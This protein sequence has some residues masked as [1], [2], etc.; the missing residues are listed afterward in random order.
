VV[1][2][3]IHRMNSAIKA[4]RKPDLVVDELLTDAAN[5]YSYDSRLVRYAI[6]WAFYGNDVYDNIHSWAKI[7]KSQ[8]ELYRHIRNIYNPTKRIIDFWRTHLWGDLKFNTNENDQLSDDITQILNW[9][10]WQSN[11]VIAAYQ[12]SLFGDTFIKI[13]DDTDKDRVYHEIVHP[14][15][16][17]ELELDTQGTLNGM[18]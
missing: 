14:G 16:I 8:Y 15:N 2:G 5:F 12:G 17:K 1:N 10:N 11:R 6:L 9:S 7:Y 3:F 4:F 13:V 18:F